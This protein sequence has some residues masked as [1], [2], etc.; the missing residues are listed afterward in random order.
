LQ[1]VTANHV[2]SG[3]A[4]RLAIADDQRARTGQVAQG[5][6][7]AFGLAFLV[8]RESERD[9][10]KTEQRQPFLQV[11]EHEVQGAGCQ[12]QQEHRFA[13]RLQGNGEKRSPLAAGQGVG[14]L[15]RQTPCRLVFAQ[16]RIRDGSCGDRVTYRTA[17]DHGFSLQRNNT[18]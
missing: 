10:H 13:H 15:R 2:A 8:E 14:A 9:Q 16:S 3:D 17:R 7:G 18:R 5:F 11:A 6:D 12:Q 4:L 1:Q